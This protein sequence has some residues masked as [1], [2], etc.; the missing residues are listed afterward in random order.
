MS[1][2]RLK[3]QNFQSHK[4][5]ILRLH[6]GM[7]AIIGDSDVGKSSIIRAATLV[8]ANK[9]SGDSFQSN[10]TDKDTVVEIKLNDDEGTTITR[11]KGKDN[12]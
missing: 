9:P 8:L 6:S 7:N 12:G 1:F 11:I 5:T 10:F 3:I 2:K 4:K